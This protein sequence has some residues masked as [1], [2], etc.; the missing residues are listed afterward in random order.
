MTCSKWLKELN[1]NHDTIKILED[2]SKSFSDINSVNIFLGQFPKV[3]ELKVKINKWDLMKLT[4]TRPA[5]G[6]R[7]SKNEKT[8]Y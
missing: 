6:T 1:T 8:T 7:K 5:K 2:I 4:S 3:I